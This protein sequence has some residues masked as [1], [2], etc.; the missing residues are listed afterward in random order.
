M[1]NSEIKVDS[2]SHGADEWMY[3]SSFKSI[4]EFNNHLKEKGFDPRFFRVREGL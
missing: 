1:L 4:E 2:W 3:Y